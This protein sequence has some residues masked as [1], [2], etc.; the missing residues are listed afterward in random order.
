MADR[1]TTIYDV[2]RAAGVAPSTVSRAFSRPGRV[3]AETAERIRTVAAELGY[4]ANP[5]ARALSTRT[6]SM[7]AVLL[8][9]IGNPVFS[10][11]ARG[12]EEAAAEAGYAMVLADT[13]ES[14]GRERELLDKILQSVDGVLLAS[15]RMSDTAVRQ[16]A[17]VKP[18]VV[19]NREVGGLPSVMVDHG[20]GMRRAAEHLAAL[21]H[22]QV[23]YL[24][25]PEAAWPDGVRW[26]A[27]RDARTELGIT[28]RRVGPVAPT[29]NGGVR[30]AAAWAAHPT[31]AVVAYNDL[32]AIGFMRGVQTMGKE[33]PQDVSVIGFDN[34]PSAEI[35][36]PGLTTVAAPQRALGSRGVRHVLAFVGGARSSSTE[37]LL[38][39]TKLVT[40]ASTGPVAGRS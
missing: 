19:L 24:A 8:A 9:D 31:S 39:P 1:P 36:T 5:Q 20:R 18:T 35:V 30:A 7:I 12:A 29:L 38:L 27:L 2:A 34:T 15:S 22:K 23:T 26:R 16:V 25:G 17:K 10:E 11:V 13:R 3:N 6:T 37:P 32:V 28:V 14:A 21:G 33:V 40:R 4:R